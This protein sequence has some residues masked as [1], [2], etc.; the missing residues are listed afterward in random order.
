M[1]NTASKVMTN[2]INLFN[3]YSKMIE[4]FRLVFPKISSIPVVPPESKSTQA[5]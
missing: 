4:Q 2:Y 3:L 1:L 5:C